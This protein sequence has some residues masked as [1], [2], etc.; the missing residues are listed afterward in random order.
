MPVSVSKIRAS[1]FCCVFVSAGSDERRQKLSEVLVSLGAQPL[2]EST[3]IVPEEK[4]PSY[5]ELCDR[6]DVLEVGEAL[7]VAARGDDD[8]DLRLVCRERDVG[9]I[10]V[11]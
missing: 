4:W 2:T 9:G 6:F 3:W 5:A 11:R 1:G 8:L 7:I 10:E